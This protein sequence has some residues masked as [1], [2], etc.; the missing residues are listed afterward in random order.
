MIYKLEDNMLEKGRVC[1]DE[2]RN[3]RRLGNEYATLGGLSL[4][5]PQQRW[6]LLNK[7][8]GH[9]TES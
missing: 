5:T 3:L 9:G 6:I 2:M 8:T 7:W 4:H 1:V